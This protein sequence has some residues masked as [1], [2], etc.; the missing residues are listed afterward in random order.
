MKKNI[1]PMWCTTVGPEEYDVDKQ[2]ADFVEAANHDKENFY[3]IDVGKL[4]GLYL[5]YK[6]QQECLTEWLKNAGYVTPEKKALIERTEKAL[7]K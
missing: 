7:G 6:E 5:A 4:W 3:A 2:M 1:R